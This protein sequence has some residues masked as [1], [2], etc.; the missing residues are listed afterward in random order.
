MNSLFNFPEK[1]RDRG[2]LYLPEGTQQAHVLSWCP[3]PNSAPFLTPP[4]QDLTSLSQ[5][6]RKVTRRSQGMSQVWTIPRSIPPSCLKTLWNTWWLTTTGLDQQLPFGLPSVTGTLLHPSI[7]KH[8]GRENNY[9]YPFDGMLA[10]K[11][12]RNCLILWGCVPLVVFSW[13]V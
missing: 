8:T 13:A 9:S 11:P 1:W 12:S 5:E 10:S 6:E 3:P 2:P 7:R 4:S